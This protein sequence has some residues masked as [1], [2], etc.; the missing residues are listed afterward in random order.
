MQTLL[1]DSMAL[2]TKSKKPV[3]KQRKLHHLEGQSADLD[4]EFLLFYCINRV[5]L[6]P[7]HAC[8]KTLGAKTSQKPPLTM[9]IPT[10]LEANTL[11]NFLRDYSSER[12]ITGDKTASFMPWINFLSAGHDVAST[13]AN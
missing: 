11:E 12:T 7:P 3:E 8:I 5:S 2:S 1:W 4:A 10:I 6:A 13:P 9:V